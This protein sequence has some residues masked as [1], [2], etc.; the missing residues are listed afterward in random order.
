M[1]EMDSE[2][3]GY[4]NH[5]RSLAVS[6]LFILPLLL[7]YEVGMLIMRP[8]TVSLAGN[9]IRWLMYEA[10]GHRAALAFNLAAMLAIG[11]SLFAL[12]KTGGVRIKIFPGVVV[13]SLAYGLLLTQFMPL[14]VAYALPMAQIAGGASATVANDIILSIGAG[15][16]E[17]I[18]FRLGVMTAVYY[19]V[20]KLS[21]KKWAAVVGAIVISSVVFSASHYLGGT[22]S[23]ALKSFVFRAIGGM[24]FAAIYI[25]RGL[26]VACYS[27]AFYDILVVTLG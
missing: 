4:F 27:H 15:V 26:A 23:P 3:Q 9:F 8:P 20:L 25:Y 22:E 12:R 2:P 19:V 11:A 10:F 14:V 1:R 16:Y 7:A 18:V 17:E 21:D 13:E 24:C 5:S 6:F